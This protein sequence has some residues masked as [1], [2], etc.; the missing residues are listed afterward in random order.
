MVKIESQFIVVR[1]TFRVAPRLRVPRRAQIRGPN[2]P[3]ATVK[4]IGEPR[5]SSTHLALMCV[6][7]IREIPDACSSHFGCRGGVD[8]FRPSFAAGERRGSVRPKLRRAA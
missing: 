1:H 6:E 5:N 8:K 7:K 4:N 2:E 3:R